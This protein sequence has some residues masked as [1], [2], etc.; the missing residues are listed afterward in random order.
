MW[1]L[2]PCAFSVTMWALFD[3]PQAGRA[4]GASP[5]P[6]WSISLAP[7]CSCAMCTT[8]VLEWA[9]AQLRKLWTPSASLWSLLWP[10]GRLRMPL[11]TGASTQFSSRA[12]CSPLSH[13]L[14]ATALC[15]NARLRNG[16]T[17][18]QQWWTRGE[19]EEGGGGQGRPLQECDLCAA[20]LHHR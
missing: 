17:P 13:F 6:T 5:V 4:M 18:R 1:A 20:A 14:I 7:A 16:G 15:P 10:S 9:L 19:G 2:S 11:M 8:S 12:R 3:V